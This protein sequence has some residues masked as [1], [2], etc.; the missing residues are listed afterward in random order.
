ME[1]QVKRPGWIGGRALPPR[2]PVISAGQLSPK[3][4]VL[5]IQG[6]ITTMIIP[7]S[8]GSCKDEVSNAHA[9]TPRTET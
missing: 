5:T 4:P 1:R 8:Q 3:K 6:T 7:S 2:H 9:T